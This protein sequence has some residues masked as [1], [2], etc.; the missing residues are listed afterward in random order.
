MAS[1]EKQIDVSSECEASN[2]GEARAQP[3]LELGSPD[4]KVT[5]KS[6]GGIVSALTAA[7]YAW[8]EMGLVRG[9]RTL[10]PGSPA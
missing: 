3:P 4:V 6:A 5:P 10:L 9:T 7:R 8:N 2:T 1:I